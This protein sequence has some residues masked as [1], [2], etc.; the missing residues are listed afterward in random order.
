MKKRIARVSTEFFIYDDWIDDKEAYDEATKESKLLYLKNMAEEIVESEGL[1][2]ELLDEDFVFGE[3][4][5][6][7]DPLFN[8]YLDNMMNEEAKRRNM[9]IEEI[10][11]DSDYFDIIY[12]LAYNEFYNNIHEFEI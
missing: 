7:A 2:I 8:Q 6:N 10:A 9:T 11:K 4:K 5:E 12:N 3:I 1:T